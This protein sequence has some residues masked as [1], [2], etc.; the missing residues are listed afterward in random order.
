M[1]MTTKTNMESE[2]A[3]LQEHLPLLCVNYKQAMVE[4]EEMLKHEMAERSAVENI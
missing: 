2:K 1:E 3:H 4:V